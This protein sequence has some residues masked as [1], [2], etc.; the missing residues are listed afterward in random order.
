[1]ELVVHIEVK[2]SLILMASYKKLDE[3]NFHLS[4][5]R[6][7]SLCLF[8]GDMSGLIVIEDLRVLFPLDKII[9]HDTSAIWLELIICWSLLLCSTFP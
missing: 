1:M 8:P 7:D 5:K 3:I 2:T 6:M 9:M 4:I